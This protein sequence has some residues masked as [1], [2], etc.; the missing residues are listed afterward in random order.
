[1][2][3]LAQLCGIVLLL[4]ILLFYRRQRKI[5]LKTGDAFWMALCVTLA[6]VIFDILSIVAIE[7]MGVI[8][9]FLVEIICKTY[10]ITL[11]G[12][13][14]CSLFYVYVDIYG[15]NRLKCRT[16]ILRHAIVG[17]VGVGF[18]C[19]LPIHYVRD[20]VQTIVYTYGPSVLVTYLFA[21]YFVMIT[22]TTTLCNKKRMNPRRRE[23]ALLWMIFWI[24]ASLIQFFNNRFLIVGYACAVGIMIL[25]LMLENP[26]TNLDRRTGLFNQSALVQYLR[27]L[28]S[29]EQSFATVVFVLEHSFQKSLSVEEEQAVKLEVSQFLDTLP[30]ALAFKRDEDETVLLF[31]SPEDAQ[32]ALQTI[33]ER[34]TFGWGAEADTFVPFR[35]MCILDS[36]LAEGEADLLYLIRYV[37]QNSKAFQEKGSVLI[38]KELVEGMKQKKRVEMLIYNAMEQDRVEVFYQPIYSTKE[39]KF[40]AAEALV[41]IRDEQGNLIP[42]GVFIDV[43]EKNGMILRLGEIIFEK[44]CCFLKDNDL[45]QYGFHYVEVNLSMVQCAYGLLAERYIA[46]MKKHHVPPQWI[47]L[48]ITESASLR[49]KKTLQ[50][51][52]KRLMDYGVHFSLDDFGTG[53]SN[54][55][56]IIDMPVDI[57]KFDRM[58][59][60]AYFENNKGKYVM[61]AAM[62][63]IH[64]LKL[65]IVSEG[66]ET[67]E[68]YREMERLGICYIQGFYFSKPLPQEAFLTFLQEHAN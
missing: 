68:Q 46:I 19:I 13:G 29:R 20:D 44:V 2:N 21:L 25:Y 36:T 1:M 40:T 23:A 8:P 24:G 62:H 17:I 45:S 28:Y 22:L 55:N 31:R 48:E 42:P 27:Q 51:N 38:D 56:Y 9:R 63:M 3:I 53:Q 12:V 39:Q 10:L 65:E 50:D 34:M 26:E 67:E 41:R 37:R 61:D 35:W 47:N 5:R 52:M 18:V 6:C 7:E 16:I 64:G 14:F 54:L 43:A 58:M 11:I 49:A 4:I 30:G 59:S 66:I 32:M 60:M 57:V 33:Q 15:D